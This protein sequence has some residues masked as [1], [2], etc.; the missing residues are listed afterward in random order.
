M[1]SGEWSLL[2]YHIAN[3]ITSIECSS[4]RP[5]ASYSILIPLK[6]NCL[7]FTSQFHTPTCS[8]HRSVHGLFGFTNRLSDWLTY[9]RLW[10]TNLIVTYPNK[11]GNTAPSPMW[12][13]S[14]T[15]C[16]QKAFPL[17]GNVALWVFWKNMEFHAFFR[18]RGQSY[19]RWHGTWNS[20]VLHRYRITLTQDCL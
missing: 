2:C 8:V 14:P 11:H 10:C 20:L 3:L 17:P 19:A 1:V 15:W 7:Y 4:I 6:G 5:T 12:W 9:I 13:A 16:K 18:G